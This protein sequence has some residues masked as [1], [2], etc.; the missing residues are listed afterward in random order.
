MRNVPSDFLF[1]PRAHSARLT[2]VAARR[3]NLWVLLA[4]FAFGWAAL[5]VS[6]Q[7]TSPVAT[8]EAPL[9][10]V[11]APVPACLAPKPGNPSAVPG[12]FCGGV[13]P[14]TVGR[15]L[16]IDRECKALYGPGASAAMDNP[17]AYGWVCKEQGQADRGIADMHQACR[18]SYGNNAIATLVGIDA[19]DWRCLTPADV[20]G[21]VLPVLLYPVDHLRPSESVFVIQSLTR[22]STLMSGVRSFY[23]GKTSALVRG[24][25][26][27][28]LL[29]HTSAVDWQNLALCTDQP[30]C[31]YIGNPYPWDN[32]NSRYIY[33]NR[34]KTELNDGQ[35]NT[36]IANSS[37]RLAAFVTLGASPA[38]TPTWCGAA[39]DFPGVV[40][41]AAP[42][43]SYASCN[44]TTNNPPDYEDAFYGAGHEFGHAM[45]LHHSDDPN[46]A[47]VPPVYVFNDTDPSSNL[48]RP[49][50]LS[51][52]IMCL[53]KGTSSE[54]FPFEVQKLL[55]FLLGWH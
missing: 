51:S 17:D 30:S 18:R 39:E 26:A 15:N 52:S 53:G 28:V 7:S 12:Q 20:S 16:D 9:R 43:G 33:L 13:P 49:G 32:V 5:P 27:F 46:C 40:S 23:Q 25:N 14:V 42:S 47:N 3:L 31:A 2:E 6:A 24:T 11:A 55:P 50:N 8:R 22:V 10:P 29:T 48:L 41:V 21:H 38:Q 1:N 54:L 45:G 36:L 37:M 34:I 4:A 35:W 19:A 44:L